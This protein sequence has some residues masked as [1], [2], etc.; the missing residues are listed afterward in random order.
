MGTDALT[1]ARLIPDLVAKGETT[2]GTE[3]TGMG[4]ASPVDV[5]RLQAVLAA[6]SST[7]VA[8]TEQVA[9]Q[10]ATAKPATVGDAILHSLQ[11]RASSIEHDWLTAKSLLSQDSVSAAHLMRVQYAVLSASVQY[12]LV[13]KGI[14][15]ASQDLDQ[16]LRTQ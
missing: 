1:A 12:D 4:P 7:Q 15:K 8:A 14:S 13:G 6:P 9:T 16:L 10:A 3:G 5:A 11:R 2:T